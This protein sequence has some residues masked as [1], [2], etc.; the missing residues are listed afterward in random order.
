MKPSLALD[1]AP[2][3]SWYNRKEVSVH[4][5]TLCGLPNKQ[6][7]NATVLSG[8][9]FLPLFFWV[10]VDLLGKLCFGGYIT[11]IDR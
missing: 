9:F 4:Y 6:H 10:N 5:F 8:L 7:W 11:L 3:I 2:S 1:H